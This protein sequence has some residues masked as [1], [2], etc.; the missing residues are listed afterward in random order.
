[1]RARN[2]KGCEN[3]KEMKGGMFEKVDQALYVWFRQMGEKGV[4]V[5]GPI[6]L[7]KPSNFIPFS[8]QKAEDRSTQVTAF[9]G[10]FVTDLASKVSR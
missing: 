3:D 6:L 4:P 1:M 5:T 2:R 7:E 10:D 9:N 8:T